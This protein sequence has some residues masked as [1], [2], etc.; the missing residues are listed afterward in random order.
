MNE[1]EQISRLADIIGD[2]A[3]SIDLLDKQADAL[4]AAIIAAA[5]HHDPRSKD[6]TA[7][8]IAH[9]AVQTIKQIRRKL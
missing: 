9:D 3:L 4:G 7:E 8:E 5:M 1:N 6:W 2:L